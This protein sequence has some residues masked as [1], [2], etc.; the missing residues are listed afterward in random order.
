[1][2]NF[3]KIRTATDKELGL[4]FTKADLAKGREGRRLRKIANWLLDEVF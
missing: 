4:F 2:Y 3:E 1:M